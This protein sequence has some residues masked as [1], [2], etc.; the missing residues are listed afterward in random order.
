MRSTSSADLPD[1]NRSVAVGPG[2]TAL[3]VMLRLRIS[4]ERIAVM[5]SIADLVAA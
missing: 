2:A 5:I 3:T 1:R 4:F